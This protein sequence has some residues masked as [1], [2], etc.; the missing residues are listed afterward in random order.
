M[1]QPQAIRAIIENLDEQR[2]LCEIVLVGG[3]GL[4]EHVFKQL[5][6]TI[7]S[8]NDRAQ[9]LLDSLVRHETVR[10]DGNITV[11]RKAS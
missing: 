11:R 5:L 6:T 4:S 7:V 8:A 3:R 9:I 1:S 2:R 10:T